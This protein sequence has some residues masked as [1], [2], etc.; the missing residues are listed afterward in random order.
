MLVTVVSFAPFQMNIGTETP[1]LL[2]APN[3]ISWN[4]SST[5]FQF[6]TRCSARATRWPSGDQH[7][8]HGALRQLASTEQARQGRDNSSTSGPMPA[9][10]KKR[11][12]KGSPLPGWFLQNVVSLCLHTPGDLAWGP[13]K[14][15]GRVTQTSALL[16]RDSLYQQ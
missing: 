16:P 4:L 11:W 13:G 9:P 15:N 2:W 6:A 14:P 5:G 8:E 3:R 12:N 1:A 10:R 7:Y